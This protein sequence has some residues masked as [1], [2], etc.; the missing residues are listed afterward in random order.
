[1]CITTICPVQYNCYTMNI[2][3]TGSR[4]GSMLCYRRPSSD[5]LRRSQHC[6]VGNLLDTSG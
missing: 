3:N 6:T 1:M 2:M 5:Q 4:T